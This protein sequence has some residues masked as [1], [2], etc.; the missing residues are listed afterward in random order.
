[1]W[2]LNLG[3]LT[4]SPWHFSLSHSQKSWRAK[5]K[6]GRAQID[7]YILGGKITMKT[8]GEI[9]KNVIGYKV[10]KETSQTKLATEKLCCGQS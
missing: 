9:V 8:W 3:L 1:M 5:E 10:Q 4:L 7:L 6:N 2:H